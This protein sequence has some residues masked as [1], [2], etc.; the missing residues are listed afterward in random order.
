MSDTM[1]RFE[2]EGPAGPLNTAICTHSFGLA[3]PDDEEAMATTVAAYI[4]KAMQLQGVDAILTNPTAHSLTGP[5]IG[6]GI[7]VAWNQDYWDDWVAID[8]DLPAA[9]G[10]GFATG[11]LGTSLAS[12][13]VSITVVEQIVSGGRHNG[14]HYLPW[15][16]KNAIDAGGLVGSSIRSNLSQNYAW[17]MLG[18]VFT[19]PT[20]AA[21]LAP[22]V[23]AT[24]GSLQGI[25][26][27]TVSANP[28]RLRSRVR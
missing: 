12:A 17:K 9:T 15:T 3:S 13:G 19:R 18:T 28:A 21:G 26:A 11:G 10:W 5:G 14:R 2:V 27:T 4:T 7:G 24:G 23:R 20:W 16:C 6:P 25:Y 8:G 22:V 1:I